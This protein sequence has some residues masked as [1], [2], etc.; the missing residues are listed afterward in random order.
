M[1]LT[2]NLQIMSLPDILQWMLH[3]KKT[4]CL[5][6]EYKNVSRSIYCREGRV[7]AC[8]AEDPSV[9]LGQFLLAHGWISEES[10]RQA[11]ARQ[12]STGQNLGSLLIEMGV[13]RQEQ[14]LHIVS[15]K[16]METIH[17]LFDWDHA[18]FTFE[19]DVE[20]VEGTIQ[21]D[22]DV[23][24]ILLEGA[25][26]MDEM[27]RIREVFPT[28]EIVLAPTD[29]SPDASLLASPIA[30][31]I[32]ECVD[33]KRTLA[34][35]ILECRV[36]EYMACQFLVRLQQ[37]GTVVV[38]EAPSADVAEDTPVPDLKHAEQLLASGDAFH[39]FRMLRELQEASPAD[40]AVKR[41]LSWAE[42]ELITG[43]YREG[44]LPECVPVIDPSV[45]ALPENGLTSTER[46]VLSKI[47]GDDTVKGLM[48]TLPLRPVDVLWALKALSDRGLIRIA[49]VA[50][51]C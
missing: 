42:T 38:R 14:M 23:T 8:A 17:G 18:S 34:E 36:S 33:G 4:G 3:A 50:A 2:G 32:Y 5:R 49:T 15:S 21:V 7:I 29:R 13:L 51:A 19:P 20:P 47:N 9:L 30:R 37:C 35:I 25:R 11:L 28:T 16:A 45:E 6:V 48:W 24:E 22:L 44:L 40:P 46:H 39:A 41:L 43:V 31:R 27:E 1:N 26:R 10:L 12:E